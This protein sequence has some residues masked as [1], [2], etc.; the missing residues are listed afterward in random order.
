MTFLQTFTSKSNW[1]IFVL[2]SGLLC[3][4]TYSTDANPSTQA[5]EPGLPLGHLVYISRCCD[6]VESDTHLLDLSTGE[7]TIVLADQANDFTLAGSPNGQ[8]L[9]VLSSSGG[10]ELLRVVDLST[11]QVQIELPGD[12]SQIGWLPDSEHIIY[13]DEEGNLYRYDLLSNDDTFVAN[14]V[15]RFSVSPDGLWLGLSKRD[16]AYGD[17]FTFRVSGSSDGELLDSLY[18]HLDHLGA[19]HSA[20][21]PTTN[22]VA[23]VF[24]LDLSKLVIFTIEQDSVQMKATAI[25][26]ETYQQDYGQDLISVEFGEMA[27]SP[28]GQRLAIARSTTDARPSGE[29]LVFDANLTSYQRLAFGEAVSRLAWIEQDWMVYV[30]AKSTKGPLDACGQLGGEIWL[31]NMETLETRILVTDTLF[32]DTPVW[33]AGK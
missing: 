6:C 22:E 20:W 27:W 19:N 10:K 11:L 15:S 25:A 5:S 4:C 28:D 23:A 29:V 16:S 26:R 9:A 17:F 14:G 24:G 13:L 3:C 33:Y 21:S 8:M 7:S 18:D 30:A 2:V 31:A 1:L 12:F 32:I